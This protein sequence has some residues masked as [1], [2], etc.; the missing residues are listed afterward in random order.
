V[1][2]HITATPQINKG[3]T[4]ETQEKPRVN[5]QHNALLPGM[6]QGG[7]HNYFPIAVY[8]KYFLL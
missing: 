7:G 1:P 5:Y 8:Q 2:P 4:Q 6:Q 3:H